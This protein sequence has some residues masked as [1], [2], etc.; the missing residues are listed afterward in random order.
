MAQ[1]RA[2]KPF[3][4][5]TQLSL[6]ELT[7]LRARTLDEL[8]EHLRTVP[9]SCIYYHT[10]HFLQRHQYLSPE[11]PNDFA[12]WVAEALGEDRI[13]EQL[14]AID[15]LHYTSIRALREKFIETLE[16]AR[17]KRP[18]SFKKPAPEDEQFYF[19]KSVS[20]VFPASYSASTLAE[21]LEA[22]GKVSI[23]SLYFHIFAARL[24][25]DKPTN[26]F[27]LWLENEMGEKEL[28]AEVSRLDP[29]THTME[30]LR[31][32]I[33]S[34]VRKRVVSSDNAGGPAKA[35]KGGKS[36]AGA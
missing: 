25:L 12:Y 21:F 8:V 9:G 1:R 36:D 28:A 23:S 15:T 4:F 2:E 31:T 17:E 14:S 20:V 16:R 35:A 24:R 26:D 29:Y 18:E 30:G 32:R 27:S 22:L 5:S 34:L 13:S 6:R 19:M 7:G 33:M 10:H 3:V 11:P